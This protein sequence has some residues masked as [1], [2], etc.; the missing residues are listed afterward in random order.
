MRRGMLA[1]VGLLFVTAS[2]A[3]AQGQFFARR[4]LASA[5]RSSM[6]VGE[7]LQLYA[8]ARDENGNVSMG[9]AQWDV[10][11]TSIASIDASGLVTA[12]GVG[13]TGVSVQR[14]E[15]WNFFS[16]EV[17][18]LRVEVSSPF[19]EIFV[20]DTIQLT[21]TAFDINGSPIPIN[22]IPNVEFEWQTHGPHGYYTQ[23]ASINQEGLLTARASGTVTVNVVLGLWGN[24]GQIQR[25]IASTNIVIRRTEEFRLTRVLAT[26]PVDRSFELIPN[27][28]TRLGYN[29]AGQ[30][31]LSASLDGIATGLLRFDN[32]NWDVLA[33]A[34]TP[35]VFSR[36]YVWDYVGT[37]MNNSGQVLT[38]TYTRGNRSGLLLASEAESRI[39]F[40]EGQTQGSFQDIGNF[41][42]G[43]HSLNDRG[44]IVFSGNYSLPTGDSNHN[45][46]FR[47][48]EEQLR[49]V[50]GTS[51]SLAEF[52]DGWDFDGDYGVDAEGVVYFDVR[53]DDTDAIYRAD[54]LS[55]PQKIVMTGD[56]VEGH[57][58][59]RVDR[60]VIAP[61]GTLAF[62]LTVGD[63]MRLPAIYEPDGDFRVLE[64]VNL[65]RVL[66][67]NARGEVVFLGDV[68]DGWG[69]C[70]W[71]DDDTSTFLVWDDV[72]G[73]GRVRDQ[74]NAMITAD[75]TIYAV[76]G[77]TES[78]F[79][80]AN[81]RTGDVLFQAGDRIDGRANLNFAGFVPGALFGPPL[82]YT[83]GDPV[84]ISEATPGE[85]TP[86]WLAW[87]SGWDDA[88]NGNLSAAARNPRRDLY[89]AAGRGMFRDLGS[90]ETIFEYPE[91]ISININQFVRIQ[92]TQ[93]WWDGG[94]TFAVND[95]GMLV[96]SANTD[97][98]YTDLI[99][100]RD[101]RLSILASF[102]GEEGTTSPTGGRFNYIRWGSTTTSTIALDDA[103]RVM[104]VADVFNG[105]NGIF[106]YENGAW[107]NVLVEDET[108]VGG[109][110]VNWVEGGI[111]AAGNRFYA[112]FG[113][114]A[115]GSMLAEYDGVAWKPIITTADFLPNGGDIY[116]VQHTFDANRRGDVALVLNARG[117]T[118]VMLRTADGEFRT[119]YRTGEATPEG[120]YFRPWQPFDVDLREDGSLYF[121]GIDILDRH[122]LYHA[123]PLP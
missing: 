42:I 41:S 57:T 123:Q 114:T 9:G 38:V 37:A 87:Q 11:D 22:G 104:M 85:P 56:V 61:D 105:P 73:D 103:G 118:T 113:L 5:A 70:L 25:L 119:V 28:W 97:D 47:I 46:I 31:S 117:G 83:G 40:V 27:P 62:D 90:M 3:Q 59:D 12:L 26:D 49:V 109:G 19:E 43:Q 77:T 91:T 96:F 36:S 64:A 106:L 74:R 34:G 80:V 110:T 50:W 78:N 29:D 35:G 8:V 79:V 107:R 20:G 86:I 89:F 18:P 122:V 66:S 93:S 21:A 102:G 68:G 81:A 60:F 15:A 6:I 71:D 98:G 65:D 32:G 111:R 39:V 63:Y 84:S 58:V 48:S 44:D 51:L 23:I 92:W 33:S 45:G 76:V 100:S 24:A 120:D 69:F 17:L 99:S 75:G 108:E 10:W 52:P 16:L 112:V 72:V 101:G 55:L 1:F 94:N 4:I 67:V 95:A 121:M 7:Q 82:I 116:W 13:N 115:G 2:L 14:D 54:G 30:I 53:Q 88:D